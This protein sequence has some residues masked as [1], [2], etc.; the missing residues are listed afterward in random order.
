MLGITG[1]SNSSFSY[2][3]VIFIDSWLQV[4][5]GIITKVEF[6]PGF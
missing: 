1:R 6:S 4:V 2:T 5:L 3:D